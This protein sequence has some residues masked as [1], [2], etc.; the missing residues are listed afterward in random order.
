MDQPIDVNRK[1]IIAENTYLL[2]LD[3]DVDFSTRSCAFAC[4]LDEKESKAWSSLWKDPPNWL[5][6]KFILFDLIFVIWL[7]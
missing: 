3:G 5:R 7:V 6:Y 2:A 1:E 4:R